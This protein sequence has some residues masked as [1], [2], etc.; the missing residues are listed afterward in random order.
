MMSISI[1]KAGLL[2]CLQLLANDV[3]QH[4]QSGLFA[5]AAFDSRLQ[6]PSVAAA[7]FD[8]RLHSQSFAAPGSLGCSRS[9]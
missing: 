3:N 9:I 5:A 6:S 1:I 8:R 7:S 2:Q 4:Y